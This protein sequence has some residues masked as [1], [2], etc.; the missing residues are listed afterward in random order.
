MK[1]VI[2][3]FDG[4]LAHTHLMCYEIHKELNPDLDYGFF[5]SLSGGN[6]HEMYEKATTEN[7]IIHNPDFHSR[8]ASD[9]GGLNVPPDLREVV[10][11]LHSRYPLFIISS[12][13][14]SSIRTFLEKEGL[15]DKF[16]KILGSDVHPLKTEKIKNLLADQNLGAD[17]VIFVTDT[18]GDIHEARKCEVECIAVSWGL[19]DRGELAKDTPYA[20]VDTPADLEKEIETYLA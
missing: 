6:F 11:R 16:G 10:L 8:Y 4:V 12:T 7:K 15:A 20:V 5:Q 1:A 18:T 3:D 13:P 2:F 19:H 9:L 14:T 17:D